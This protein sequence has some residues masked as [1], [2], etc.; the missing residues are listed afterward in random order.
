MMRKILAVTALLIIG[1]SSFVYMQ[2]PI[3]SFDP[4]LSIPVGSGP[5]SVAI[6]D[7]NAD[8]S[9]D[10]IVANERSNSATVLLGNDKGE[11][12][13]SK[14]SPWPAG[15]SPN[16]IAVGDF[17]GDNKLDLAFPNHETKFVTVLL[18]DGLG[19]FNFASGSPFT[20]RSKPHPHGIAAGELNGDGYL[21]LAVESSRQD[22]VEVLFGDGKGDF[23]T[24]GP[25]FAVGRMP[26]QKVRVGD[27]NKDGKADIITT[28]F[29]GR[30]VT[31]LLGDGKGRFAQAK[32]S[33]FAV[34]NFPFCAAIGDV[35]GDG[36]PDLAISHYSG[37]LENTRDDS[38]TVLLGDGRSKFTKA[39]GSPF[40][41]GHAPVSVALGDVDGNDVLD[42]GVANL[43][44][45]NVTILL[46]GK[47]GIAEAEGSPFAVGR[48]PEGIALGDLNGDGRADIVTANN[49]GNDITIL[50]S[51]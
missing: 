20:V 31:A 3:V 44:G 15:K 13:Q 28:D 30:S 26:Y 23:Q 34:P 4:A 17:N 19:G 14:G 11:F 22:Q 46:G 51:K 8:G 38:L 10:I 12:T 9:P 49:Q 29:R 45:D 40:R 39:V 41:A 24:P 7:I 36:D 16:D 25:M 48:H 32:G 42:I 50:L 1:L 37:N 43:G 21:D 47:D 5:V 18:G 27:L 6:T 2:G 35:N 33:P